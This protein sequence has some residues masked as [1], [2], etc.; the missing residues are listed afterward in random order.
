MKKYFCLFTVICVLCFSACSKKLDLQGNENSD[1]VYYH[2]AEYHSELFFCTDDDLKLM[3]HIENGAYVYSVG[4]AAPPEFIEIVGSDNSGV[5]IRNGSKVPVSGTVTEVL[6]DPSVRGDNSKYLSQPEELSVL[7]EL[8]KISGTVQKFTVH[9]YFT[10]G[11][12]FYYVYD[13]SHV[14]CTENYGGY[15]AY[16]NGVWVFASPESVEEWEWGDGNT[17]TISGII[18]EDEALIAK[19]CQTDIVK[20]ISY[21]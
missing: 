4:T 12:A 20:Y 14:S 6:I 21:T 10:D 7:S 16:T 8:T 11:N 15:I 19:M 3:G 1:F 9:N 18:I 5:F 17:V 13:N 2:G